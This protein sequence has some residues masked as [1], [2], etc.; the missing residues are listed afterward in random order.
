MYPKRAFLQD[1]SESLVIFEMTTF[2]RLSIICAFGACLFMSTF[3][4]GVSDDALARNPLVQKSTDPNIL[5]RLRALRED[6][7]NIGCKVNICFAIQ[8]GGSISPIDFQDQI[9]FLD[10]IAN[11]LTT[12]DNGGLCAV[13]YGRLATPISFL[14]D[15]R[16]L[17]A[18]RLDMATQV[19]GNQSNIAAALGY[20][21]F[22]LRPQKGANKIVL[23]ADGFESVGSNPKRI[24]QKIQED[25]IQLCAVGVGEFSVARLQD[26]VG[27][28]ERVLA[29]DGFF[30]LLEII[31]ALVYEVCGM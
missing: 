5:R 6:V 20:T 28:P 18:K 1:N 24:A 26:I 22:Q 10:L 16:P 13:Q 15:N 29:T 30:E 7:Q 2:S 19:G 3:A 21:A 27:S 9:N 25:G 8:G 31:D 12:D 14:T 23:F 4:I 11:V 17:F